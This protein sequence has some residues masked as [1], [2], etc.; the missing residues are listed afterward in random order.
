MSFRLLLGE[1]FL[2]FRH[3]TTA[4][5]V[6]PVTFQK[7]NHPIL[8]HLTPDSVPISSEGRPVTIAGDYFSEDLTYVCIVGN[9]ADGDFVR[10]AKE[11]RFARF[12]SIV[13]LYHCFSRNSKEH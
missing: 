12:F 13:V 3:N 6:T 5:F 9:G 10:E 8:N 4:E 1:H 2:R 11:A 7:L